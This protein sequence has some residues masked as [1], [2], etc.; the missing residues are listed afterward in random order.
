TR[1]SW[2]DPVMTPAPRP[3]DAPRDVVACTRAGLPEGGAAGERGASAI[4][5]ADEPLLRATHRRL[6]A[7]LGVREDAS[8]GELRV[9]A[10][11]C[12]TRAKDVSGLIEGEPPHAPKAVARVPA[13]EEGLDDLKRALGLLGA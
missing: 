7:R 11:E 5:P 1:S 8:G 9:V 2:L 13:A 4:V 3:P 6:A 12:Y 10:A